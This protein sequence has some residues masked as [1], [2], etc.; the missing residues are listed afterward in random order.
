MS[1]T[2][3]V[4]PPAVGQGSPEIR[5]PVTPYDSY[6]EAATWIWSEIKS[7]ANRERA[8]KELNDK[9]GIDN[10]GA[11]EIYA[12]FKDGL[13][14][15]LNHVPLP[16]THGEMDP[17]IMADRYSAGRI[18]EV[19]GEEWDNFWEMV[20][21][22]AQTGRDLFDIAKGMTT[23]GYGQSTLDEWA[24]GRLK[25][26]QSKADQFIGEI[27]RQLSP[28]GMERDPVRAT[29]TA[30]ALIPTPLA[31]GA[32]RHIPLLGRMSRIADKITD[33][34]ALDPVALAGSGVA[35]G[36]GLLNIISKGKG[37]NRVGMTERLLRKAIPFEHIGTARGDATRVPTHLQEKFGTAISMAVGLP[38]RT[39]VTQLNIQNQPLIRGG[40]VVEGK[41]RGDALMEFQHSTP[42]DRVERL[43]MKAS[44]AV[45]QLQ[46]NANQA[47]AAGKAALGTKLQRNLKHDEYLDFTTELYEKVQDFGIHFDIVE[48]PDPPS[49]PKPYPKRKGLKVTYDESVL[50][51]YLKD[52]KGQVE[53]VLQDI[54][55]L[56]HDMYGKA[57]DVTVNDIYDV[58]RDVDQL[59]SSFN[60]EDK[61]TRD[62]RATYQAIRQTLQDELG[63]LV[64]PE[65]NDVMR[66]YMDHVD[67]LENLNDH[68]NLAPG[69]VKRAGGRIRKLE[70]GVEKSISNR[71]H[72]TLKHGDR[73]RNS[74]D[75]LF[76][77]EKMSG[78]NELTPLL[79]A[80][81]SS[82]MI[83]SN[84]VARHVILGGLML[85]GS[86]AGVEML[87]GGG[88]DAGT[89]A[90]MTA[91]SAVGALATSLSMDPRFMT[92]AVGK[93]QRFRNWI[94]ENRHKAREWEP[95][96]IFDITHKAWKYG[97][98]VGRTIEQLESARDERRA[99][100]RSGY[101]QLLP[102]Q[103]QTPTARQARD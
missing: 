23:R 53:R 72:E 89:M 94:E 40:K 91:G 62:A 11:K 45:D 100:P 99:D 28:A 61:I 90:A 42:T 87:L 58:R 55:N 43:T 15:K 64:G 25:E 95:G 81:T 79:I 39:I 44:L 97:L 102:T 24:G 30:S 67:V 19:A 83:S 8:K 36:R 68:L 18:G 26:Q 37:P 13:V 14:N 12:H 82:D 103:S 2:Q 17:S 56:D 84:L 38:L 35:L 101:Q 78:N 59:L 51:V 77:L 71:L 73:A 21:D 50:G 74:L 3:P 86:G 80:S 98:D 88:F 92:S 85:G 69:M 29:A 48:L 33:Y 10:W 27:G 6:E 70:P 22:P 34:T 1:E 65:Y 75:M 52:R 63:K 76:A 16:L 49:G 5:G 20:S 66:D 31:V 4:R 60:L 96:A 54:V 57:R 47:Y 9:H 46:K 32:T 93:S 41:T 7:E